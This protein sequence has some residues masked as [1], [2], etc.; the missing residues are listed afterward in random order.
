LPS[1]CGIMESPVH[2]WVSPP[3]GLPLLQGNHGAYMQHSSPYS[4]QDIVPTVIFK[5]VS[6]LVSPF[7]YSLGN[8]YVKGALGKVILRS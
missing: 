1:A 7:L 8:S 6:T 4:V 2:M 3:C 5:T